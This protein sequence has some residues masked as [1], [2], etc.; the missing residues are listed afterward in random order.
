M[1]VLL[2]ED[3]ADVAR[4]IRKGLI[5][6]AY[7]ID[8]ASVRDGN[9][10]TLST[11]ELGAAAFTTVNMG[12]LSYR[13]GKVLFWNDE[14][15]KEVTADG[16]WAKRLEQ[17]SKERGKPEQIIGWNGGNS[18]SVVIPPAYQKLEGPWTDGKDP[19]DKAASSKSTE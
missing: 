10:E 6:Q 15:K 11:P 5:E 3:D 2:V 7:A 17:R 18:G 13:N 16:S 8:L 9:R 14:Q 1:R 12:V 4:F 19:A